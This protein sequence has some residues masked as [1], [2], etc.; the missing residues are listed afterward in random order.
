MDDKWLESK[1]ITTEHKSV[2]YSFMTKIGASPIVASKVV[3]DT[4]EAMTGDRT[5]ADAFMFA[6][7]MMR[8]VAMI[9]RLDY[10]LNKKNDLRQR[11]L[12]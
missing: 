12:W 6:W 8:R 2:I 5:V 7:T 9:E 3:S 1:K 4:E 10:L 11:E